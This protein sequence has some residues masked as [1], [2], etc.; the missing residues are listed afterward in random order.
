LNT[1]LS[2]ALIAR[3]NLNQRVSGGRIFFVAP[4]VGKET[5]QSGGS[6]RKKD[7]VLFAAYYSARINGSQQRRA[8]GVAVTEIA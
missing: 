4:N 2:N 6:L 3:Y 7:T 5:Q 1:G 8:Q